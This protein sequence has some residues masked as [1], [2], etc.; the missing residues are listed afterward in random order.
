M[1]FMSATVELNH[2]T[3]TMDPAS[4]APAMIMSFARDAG[5][6]EDEDDI[7]GVQRWILSCFCGE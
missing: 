7:A 3:D 1:P 2:G 6:E 5:D 4:W